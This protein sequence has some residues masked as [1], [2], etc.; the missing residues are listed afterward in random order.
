M[1]T[2]WVFIRPTLVKILF[3]LILYGVVYGLG[4]YCEEV[5]LYMK[6][7][8]PSPAYSF[9]SAIG[10]QA[11]VIYYLVSCLVAFIFRIL[12]TPF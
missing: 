11:Y 8:C 9:F 1:I 5:L 10:Y 6:V 12:T 4:E 2:L 3:F 7:T